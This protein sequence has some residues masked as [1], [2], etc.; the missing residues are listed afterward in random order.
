MN[1]IAISISGSGGSGVVKTGLVLLHSLAN[2]GFYGYMSRF[3]GPQ[4]RG[5]ESAVVLHFAAYEIEEAPS[6]SDIHLALD[7][8]GFE[9]FSDEIPLNENTDV[10]YDSSHDELPEC[11][12]KTDAKLISVSLRDAVK[13]SKGSR[14]NA[15]AIGIIVSILGVGDDAVLRALETVFTTKDVHMVQS[16]FQN[17]KD[18]YSM[19][20]VKEARLA[21]WRATQ[22]KRWII[23]GNE[24]SALGALRGG[25]TFAAAYPI[26]PAT[27][28]TEYLA[29]R[30]EKMG[31]SLLIAED[32]LAAMN[33]VI[34]ASFG[35]H[36]SLTA[37]SGPGF[38]LMSEA[39]GLA[40]ASEIPAL[41][42]NVNRG[43]PSTGI[44][45]KSEQTDLNQSLYGMHGEAPHI[46]VAPLSIADCVTTTQWA[47][48]LA[49]ALQTLVVELI[50]QRLGQSRVIINSVE[51]EAFNLKR[52]RCNDCD[53]EAAYRRYSIGEDDISPMAIPGMPFGQY[54]ADGLEHD[55][56]GV[57]SSL[58]SDHQSQLKKRQEKI[59]SFDY[60]DRWAECIHCKEDEEAVVITWGSTFTQ[61][62][63]AVEALM[64]EGESIA[65]IA[66]RLLMPLRAD[67]IAEMCQGK[68]VIVVEQSFS[69]QFYHYCL[70]Q[71]AIEPTAHLLAQP[72]PLVLKIEE[73]KAFIR[74]VLL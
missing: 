1:K 60:G 49:E 40:I 42:I 43:G 14:A 32:E 20:E 24:A 4:I 5:G 3:S 59:T 58:A 46:V 74:K 35:G 39:M 48:G 52:K 27:E 23:S 34:G 21:H 30:I 66:P 11:V 6:F 8:K 44:P 38:S 25:V 10:I 53:E 17:I 61:V 12:K 37:T 33:M 9:R 62:K 72:G 47:L 16:I 69:G 63:L 50:D 51:K 65:L 18:G 54:T 71:H 55:L 56:F 57:P 2:M 36:A 64:Q 13:K 67:A 70:S 28:I 68:K 41:V 26:T 29:P 73:I 31:G 19:V 7:W 15:F 45:T 22:E